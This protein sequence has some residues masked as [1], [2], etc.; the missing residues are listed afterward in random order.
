MEKA[1]FLPLNMVRGNRARVEKAEL[2]KLPGFIGLA[3]DLVAYSGEM[4]R[5]N[6]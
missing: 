4:E 6:P 3:S 2:D 5:D 1:T